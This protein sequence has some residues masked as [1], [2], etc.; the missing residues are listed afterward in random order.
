MEGVEVLF[1]SQSFLLLQRKMNKERHGSRPWIE[2]QKDLR[3]MTEYQFLL[4]HFI[5]VNGEDKDLLNNFW[6]TMEVLAERTGA[7]V[8]LNNLR[9]GQIS[10]VAVHKIMES[11]GSQPKL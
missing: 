1:G 2:I 3:D 10:Q 9:R 11:L 6:K 5:L 8:E 4:T 7:L